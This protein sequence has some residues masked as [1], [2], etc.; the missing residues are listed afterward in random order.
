MIPMDSIELQLAIKERFRL[1][2]LANRG[3]TA[4][5]KILNFPQSHL[6]EAMSKHRLDRMPRAD[7]IMALEAHCGQPIVTA[8]M[9]DAHGLDLAAR[10]DAAGDASAALHLAR[11]AKE[12]GDVITQMAQAL[13][14]GT[15]TRAERTSL[16]SELQ[17][18]IDVCHGAMASLRGEA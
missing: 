4:A 16:I 5:E 18:A 8:F 10:P 13:A 15:I 9:A 3:P 17:Q 1:L 14:D 7:H 6:S 12:T 11:I 2:V